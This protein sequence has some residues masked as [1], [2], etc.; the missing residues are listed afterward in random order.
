MGLW[1]ACSSCLRIFTYGLQELTLE[2]IFLPLCQGCLTYQKKSNPLTFYI[3]VINHTVYKSRYDL[4][5]LLT[6]V[7]K[8]CFISPF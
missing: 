8:Y 7:L 4:I 5:I 2:W 1:V 3:N 6:R